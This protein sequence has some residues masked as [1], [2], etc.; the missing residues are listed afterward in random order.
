M[1]AGGFFSV[2]LGFGLGS[3]GLNEPDEGRYANIA[4]A[5]AAPGG[6]WWEPRQSGYGH[7]DKPPLIYWATALSFRAFGLNEWAARLPAL[8]GAALRVG[9]ARLGG[10]S[11]A[12]RAGGLVGG[13]HRGHLAAILGDGP[14]FV[15]RYPAHRLVWSRHRG[16]G[17]MPPSRRFVEVLGL[18]H[19]CSGPWHGG[20]K[21][22][23]PSSPWQVWRWAF[24]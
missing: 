4:M 21:P 23:L 10:R 22:P 24:G 3:R 15:A 18:C 6:D 8:F 1:A 9:R 2:L 7:Y 16:V 13:A 14:A 20:P 11:P 12:R 5:M 19:S 17:G